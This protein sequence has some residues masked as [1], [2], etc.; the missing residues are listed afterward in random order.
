MYPLVVRGWYGG[1]SA[2]ER[3]LL[4]ALVVLFLGITVGAIA[5]LLV[6]RL[7][8]ALDVDDAVE[9]TSFERTARQLDGSTV[10]F[11]SRLVGAFVF[12]LAGL[13]AIR[14]IGLVPEEALIEEIGAFLPQLFVA[15][16][17]VLVGLVVGDKAEIVVSERLRSVKLPEVAVVGTLL[18]LSILYVA[19]LVALSQL[20]VATAA[21]LILLAAYTFGVFFLA[22]LAFKDLLA[23]AAAGVYLLMTEPYAIGDEVEID[24][25]R[26][27]VQEID[28]FVTCIEDDGE[29][30][31]VP[32]RKVLREGAMRIRG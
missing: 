32:N 6:R 26:G 15:I 14:T 18:K 1:L 20:G 13:Y 27:V 31:V 2:P 7:L 8:L 17:V 24:G 10:Q 16:V 22:G 3:N 29:E 28:V 25:H 19:S 30:Y 21:L 12:F 23:S 5:A 9:G 11:L 4:T